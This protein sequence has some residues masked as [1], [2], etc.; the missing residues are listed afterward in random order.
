[1]WLHLHACVRALLINILY[2]IMKKNLCD[3]APLR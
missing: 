2:N 3:A 1:M